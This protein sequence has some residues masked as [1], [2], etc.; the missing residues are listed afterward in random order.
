VWFVASPWRSARLLGAS[1][2]SWFAAAADL[3]GDRFVVYYGDVLT[4]VDLKAMIGYHANQNAVCTLA[5]STAVPIEHGVGRVQCDGRLNCFEKPILKEYPISMGIHVLAKEALSYCRPNTDLARDVM[6]R[7]ILTKKA[8]MHASLG[9]DTLTLAHSR[10]LKRS[11]SFSKTTN[12][13]SELSLRTKNSRHPKRY[14][15]GTLI[16]ISQ[17]E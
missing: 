1:F 7:L 14:F 3:L 16:S 8:S 9:S 15:H 4:D 13:S 6:P 11:D 12:R 2:A 17:E 10:P 5:M